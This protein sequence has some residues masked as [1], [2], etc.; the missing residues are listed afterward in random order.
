MC[1]VSVN[2]TRSV[3]KRSDL[4]KL[5]CYAIH[6][7]SQKTCN[8]CFASLT[9]KISNKNFLQI[10]FFLAKITKWNS[11]LWQMWTSKIHRMAMKCEAY[12]ICL[13][14][15]IDALIYI[16]ISFRHANYLISAL[17][18][19]NKYFTETTATCGYP[20]TLKKRE[21]REWLWKKTQSWHVIIIVDHLAW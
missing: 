21:Q 5:V 15:F 4:E 2:G 13:R 3:S 20:H 8:A 11:F 18:Y 16:H 6:A 1:T 17:I 10:S 19:L 9:D 7:L 12:K 14:T